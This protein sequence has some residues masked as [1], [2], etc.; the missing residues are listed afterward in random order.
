LVTAAQTTLEAKP[1]WYYPEKVNST[2]IHSKIAREK[3][4]EGSLLFFDRA[5]A[6]TNESE[7]LK[8][9]FG[10]SLDL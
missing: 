6:Y 3:R 7:I 8:L 2:S 4:E 1:V 9:F 5:M 10:E